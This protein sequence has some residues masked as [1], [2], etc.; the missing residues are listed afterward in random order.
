MALK[1][2]GLHDSL[3]VQLAYYFDKPHFLIFNASPNTNSITPYKILFKAFAI[4]I[5]N[6]NAILLKIKLYIKK[7]FNNEDFDK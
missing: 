6:I 7:Y 3:P 4:Y 2:G 1:K 5:S